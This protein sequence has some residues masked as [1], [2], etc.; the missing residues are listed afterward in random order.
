MEIFQ[1]ILLF[2]SKFETNMKG[3]KI[4]SRT[5]SLNYCCFE[6]ISDIQTYGSNQREI[7]AS[8]IKRNAR[9]ISTNPIPKYFIEASFWD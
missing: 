8:K 5:C 6:P 7:I 1:K 9:A 3:K 2:L 4:A